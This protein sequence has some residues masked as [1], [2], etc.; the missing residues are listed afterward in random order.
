V[1]ELIETSRQPRALGLCSTDY[2]FEHLRRPA[3]PGMPSGEQRVSFTPDSQRCG[4][5]LMA[6]STRRRPLVE[7]DLADTL[8]RLRARER[9]TS[10]LASCAKSRRRDRPRRGLYD[11]RRLANLRGAPVDCIEGT[12]RGL[13]V[14]QRRPAGQRHQLCADA[15]DPDRFPELVPEAPESYVL[16]AAAMREAFLARSRAVADPEFLDVPCGDLISTEW[17]DAAA[18]RIRAGSKTRWRLR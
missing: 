9:A 2:A 12:F 7:P 5:D 14:A 4:V 6:A 18:D 16:L 10:T 15:A 8:E 17:A 13:S 3:Q 11:C 1:G